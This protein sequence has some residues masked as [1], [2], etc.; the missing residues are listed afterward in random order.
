M[1]TALDSAARI[2]PDGSAPK[3]ELKADVFV[4]FGITGDLAKVMTFHSLYRL[5]A[6]GLLSCPIAPWPWT[7]ASSSRCSTIRRL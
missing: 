1:S 5:E 2:T 4:I 3:K 6:R 7:T